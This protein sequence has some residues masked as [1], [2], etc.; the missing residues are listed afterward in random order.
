M[1]NHRIQYGGPTV[2]AGTFRGDD[3]GAFSTGEHHEAHA[4]VAAGGHAVEMDAGNVT[5]TIVVSHASTQDVLRATNTTTGNS[6]TLF[7]ETHKVTATSAHIESDVNVDGKLTTHELE[8]DEA[9]TGNLNCETLV[10]EQGSI[11]DLIEVENVDGPV[12]THED[13]HGAN[14]KK[15]VVTRDPETGTVFISNLVCSARSTQVDSSGDTPAGFPPG[16]VVDQALL[17]EQ[18]TMVDDARIF[19]EPAAGHGMNRAGG[20]VFLCQTNV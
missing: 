10:T 1:P 6:L 7:D 5:G 15:T 9:H 8:C 20:N 3:E 16:M 14:A 19:F 2:F 18:I 12:F 17:T 13:D 11:T 4:V